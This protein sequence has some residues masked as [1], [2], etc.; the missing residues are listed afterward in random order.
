MDL[1]SQLPSQPPP[2]SLPLAPASANPHPLRTVMIPPT[3]P[4]DSASQS[5][6]TPT[7]TADHTHAVSAPSM[8]LST[9]PTNGSKDG[10]IQGGTVLVTGGCGYIGSHTVLDLLLSNFAVVIVDDL[11]NATTE[12][13]AHIAHLAGLPSA[14]SIPFYPVSVLNEAALDSIFASHP[15]IFAVIHLAAKKVVAESVDVPLPY[16][17]TNVSGTITL[18][19]VMAKHGVKQ[20]VFASSAA[21][22]GELEV[23]GSPLP[24]DADE[25]RSFTSSSSSRDSDLDSN[26]TLDDVDDDE[27]G[28]DEHD[29]SAQRR[30][31]HRMPSLHLPPTAPL[32]V[33]PL[34]DPPSSSSTVLLHSG[35]P[36]PPPP[37]TPVPPTT[38]ACSAPSPA[39]A[40]TPPHLRSAS[41][42]PH[43]SPRITT[44]IRRTH[45]GTRGVAERDG[46]NPVNPYGRSK[47]FA[48]RILRDVSASDPSWSM[49]I[50]R[51]FNPCGAHVSG[52]LGDNPRGTPSN[53]MP[54]L[55]KVVMGELKGGAPLYVYG[56]GYPTR[57]GTAVRDYVH[58]SDLAGAH[59][60]AVRRMA[61]LV[62]D[63][64]GKGAGCAIYNIGTGAG[65]TVMEMVRAMEL[66]SGRSVPVVMAAPRPGD[67][68]CVVANAEL[69]RR[70]LGWVPTRSVID[71]CRDTWNWVCVSTRSSRVVRE[72]VGSDQSVA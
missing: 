29:G 67:V 59:V 9:K 71:M 39:P 69:A 42:R 14:A 37:V 65:T 50:L 47:A 44:G 13:L 41:S 48:E 46:T 5:P 30:P 19:R 12:P 28:L 33:D 61:A 52:H 35:S 60:A 11:S 20:L 38:T 57:D 4:A 64:Q 36:T 25:Y 58:V 22:Y 62:R 2:P 45:G 15:S 55:A 17:D 27:N 24:P 49:T 10:I 56:G 43:P 31:R 1:F 66:V 26:G 23:A 7:P 8:Q 68:A 6:A 70:E 53:L 40:A 63:H 51:Y 72:E 21:V 3:T 54:Y 34:T 32:L 18:L 16:Y